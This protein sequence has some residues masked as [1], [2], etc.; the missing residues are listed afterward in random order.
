MCSVSDIPLAQWFLY[1]P[2]PLDDD[3]VD[4]AAR[5]ATTSILTGRTMKDIRKAEKGKW[6]DLLADFHKRTRKTYQEIT[7]GKSSRTSDLLEC[8]EALEAFAAAGEF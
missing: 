2:P 5:K 1:V 8:P 4:K 3:D 7:G 6:A